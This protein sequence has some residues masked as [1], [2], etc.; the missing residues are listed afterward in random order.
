MISVKGKRVLL[1]LSHALCMNSFWYCRILL[2][3]M[4]RARNNQPCTFYHL[5]YCQNVVNDNLGIEWI[6][7]L[8]CFLI[9]H[10]P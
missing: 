4:K 2:K 5:L 1:A 3:N 8:I 9:M 6:K 7:I 10:K